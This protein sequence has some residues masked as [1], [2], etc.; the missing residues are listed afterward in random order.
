MGELQR[1][2]QQLQASWQASKA[3]PATSATPSNNS[4]G[5]AA[6]M[7]QQ[8]AQLVWLGLSPGTVAALQAH[9]TVLPEATPVNLNTASAEVLSAVLPGL[10]LASA[11]QAV[12]QRQRGH[13]ASL[14]AAQEALGAS[15]RLLNDKQ[16]S[17]QSRYF[18]VQGRMR[19]DNVVQQ[20]TALVRRDGSQV[21]MLWRVRSPQLRLDA[22]LQ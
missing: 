7:P 1:L 10:D 5:A 21:R 22:P 19:I 2:A 3:A 17:V 15:G 20:E 9:I 16:H 11:R 14:N 18:E 12:T 4:P 13:W 8:T 6:L